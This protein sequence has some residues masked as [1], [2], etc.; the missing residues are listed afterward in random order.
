MS[1]KE[2][3]ENI[4]TAQV[5]TLAAALKSEKSANGVHSSGDFIYE[6]QRLIQQ[7]KSKILNALKTGI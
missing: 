5:L 7:Q 4:L 3:L 1:E 2:L 6:A